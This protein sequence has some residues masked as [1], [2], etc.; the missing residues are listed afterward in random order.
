M[1]DPSPRRPGA[2]VKLTHP[3]RVYWPDAG[4]TKQGLADYYA[5]VW[6]RIEPLVVNRPLALLRC[7]AAPGASASS[8]STP[9]KATASRS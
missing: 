3:D 8:R 9:G 2:R 6:P 7:P 5:A 1:P 4:V